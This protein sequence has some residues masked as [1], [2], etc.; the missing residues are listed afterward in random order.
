[1]AQDERGEAL[2][3]VRANGWLL[4]ESGAQ[5]ACHGDER[6]GDIAGAAAEARQQGPHLL[7][8]IPHVA[9]LGL[10]TLLLHCGCALEEGLLHRQEVGCEEGKTRV[11]NVTAH[12]R[13]QPSGVLGSRLADGDRE[14][15]DKSGRAEGLSRSAEGGDE[16][17]AGIGEEALIMVEGGHRGEELGARW[18]CRRPEGGEERAARAENLWPEKEILGCEALREGS[19]HRTRV[20]LGHWRPAAAR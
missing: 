7:V 2:Q 9:S 12:Y 4:V 3:N 18:M 19:R 5:L 20:A 16:S 17:R 8:Q 10:A 1:L 13:E 14:E 11:A 15:G 6:G